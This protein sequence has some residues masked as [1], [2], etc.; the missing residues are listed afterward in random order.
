MT[1][2]LGPSDSVW[3]A[4]ILYISYHDMLMLMYEQRARYDQK[5]KYSSALPNSFP[6]SKVMTI[7]IGAV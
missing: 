1:G 2:Q 5:K 7:F 4:M 3:D 6:F